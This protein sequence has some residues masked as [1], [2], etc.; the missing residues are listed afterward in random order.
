MQRAVLLDVDG[1]LVDSNDAH[2]NVWVEVLAEFDIQAKFDEV[3][4]RIGKGGDKMLPEITGLEADSAR[5]KE[6]SKRRHQL[7]LSKY[8]PTLRPLPGAR[9]LLARLSEDGYRLVVATSASEEEMNPLLDVVGARP[10]LYDATNASDA[11]HSKPDPDIVDAALKKAGVATA[12]ALFLGDTPYDIEAARKAGVRTVAVRSGGWDDE[13]LIGAVAVYDDTAHILR[14]YESS[15]FS[16]QSFSA[17][18]S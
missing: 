5:G 13:G 14:D 9:D 17:P 15:P 4:T 8:L 18:S 6:I 11:A 10:Y 12:A 3:R 16:A 1:T 7:F 2:A